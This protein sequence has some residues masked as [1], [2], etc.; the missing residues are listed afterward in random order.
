MKTTLTPL[1]PADFIGPAPV[2][3]PDPSLPDDTSAGDDDGSAGD[4]NA[5]ISAGEGSPDDGEAANERF[6]GPRVK[7]TVEVD[8]DTFDADIEAAFRKLAREVRIPGF[9][10]GRAPRRVLESHFGS[11]IG[12]AQALEEALPRY[13][14]EAVRDNHVD[15]VNQPELELTLDGSEGPVAF[16]ATVEVRPVVS[17][18]GYEGLQIEIPSPVPTDEEIDT[19]IDE[20]RRQFADIAEV[21]R[22]AAQGDRVTIDIEGSVEGEPLPGLSAQDYLYEVGSGGI[23][24]EVDEHLTGCEAGADLSFSAPHP[25]QPEMEIDFEITVNTVSELVLPELTDDWVDDNTEHDSVAEL[26]DATARQLSFGRIMQANMVLRDEAQKQ[27]A[28]LVEG[29]VPDAMVSGAIADRMQE[30]GSGLQQR[31]MTIEEW[32]EATGQEPVS[33]IGELR[34]DAERGVRLDLALRAV[35]AAE[36][37]DADDDDIDGELE[38]MAATDGRSADQLREV[39]T[40]TDGLAHLTSAICKSKALQWA[41]EAATLIGPDGDTIE[42]SALELPTAD[43]AGGADDTDDNLEETDY[44]DRGDTP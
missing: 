30:L 21:D 34:D 17:V 25:V 6:I 28:E 20:T 18:S 40:E 1:D 35:A 26:R 39:I 36:A 42:R 11:E 27:I 31:N 41:I 7:L 14:A 13:Y 2:T 19:R 43:D 10:P 4:E 5:D 23:V 12:R 22:A 16:E 3:E 29:P 8:A 38:R 44:D 32:L 33:F 9:R 24:P 37:L 15:V